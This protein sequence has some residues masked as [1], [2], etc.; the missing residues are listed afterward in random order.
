MSRK[1]MPR[2]YIYCTNNLHI[3]HTENSIRTALRDTV[4]HNLYV[5]VCVAVFV[6]GILFDTTSIWTL[7]AMTIFPKNR[8]EMAGNKRSE[9]VFALYC[10]NEAYSELFL[11]KHKRCKLKQLLM[12]FKKTHPLWLDFPQ[13]LAHIPQ[14]RSHGTHTECSTILD[15]DYTQSFQI[16]CVEHKT[17]MHSEKL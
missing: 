9:R 16:K 7:L 13:S 17:L 10:A 2:I 15:Y 5:F 12:T 11:T 14:T 4:I 1:G 3:Q 8:R 6:C